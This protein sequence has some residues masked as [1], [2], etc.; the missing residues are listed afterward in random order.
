MSHGS[1]WNRNSFGGVLRPK[2]GSIPAIE[3][4][5][6]R[7]LL[8]ADI[9]VGIDPLDTS[10]TTPE[11]TGTVNDSAASIY[12][13]VNGTD[14]D[15][16]VN[17]GD[18]TWSL[19]DD[20]IAPALVDGT[21]DVEVLALNGL[22]WGVDTTTDEL[23]IDTI[24]PIVTINDLTTPDD[25]PELTGT[26]DQP[27][28]DIIVTV[29][30]KD[31][32]E[33]D[34]V[35]NNGDGTWT[36]PDDKIDPALTRGNTYEVTVTATDEAGNVGTDTTEKELTI[37]NQS[38][39]VDVLET[40]DRTPEL[41]G[42]LISPDPVTSVDV[43][44]DGLTYTATNNGNDTWTLANNTIASPLSDGTYDVTVTVTTD[45]GTLTD[46]STN[47]LTI[48]ATG[49]TVTVDSLTTNDTTPELTGTINDDEATIVVTVNETDYPAT[50]NQDGT[51]TLADGTL[52]A[53]D[54]DTYDVTVTGTDALGNTGT[55]TTEDELVIDTIAPVVTADS[56]TID[57]A[58]F[59]PNDPQPELTGTVD[60]DEATITV[61]ILGAEYAATNNEDGTWTL[62]AD[63]TILRLF[64]GTY[65]LVVTATDPA[66]NEGT[67][68]TDNGLTNAPYVSVTSLGTSDN[69]PELTG[70]VNDPDAVVTV[71]ILAE[72]AVGPGTDY[73]AT[74]NTDGT[75]TLADGVIGPLAAGP[76]DVSLSA[77]DGDATYDED[78]AELFINLSTAEP[79]VTVDPLTTTFT[80]PPLSGTLDA[81]TAA[82][83]FATIN[84][85]VAGRSATATNNGD[86][87]W[88]LPEG[89]F[90]S[91]LSQNTYNVLVTVTDSAGNTA[92]DNTSGELRIRAEQTVT[93]R[94][95]GLIS[96]NYTDPDG[97][98]VRIKLTF[99]RVAGYVVLSFASNSLITFVHNRTAFGKIE[100]DAGAVVSSISI[101]NETKRIN[102]STR[103]GTVTGATIGGIGGNAT[104]RALVAS[105]MDLIDDGINM[106]SGIIESISLRSIQADVTMSG[107]GSK[108]VSFKIKEDVSGSNIR[109]SDC[110]VRSFLAGKMLNSS[111]YVGVMGTP[112]ENTDDVYDLPEIADL[113]V[114]HKILRFTI[115][116]YRGSTGDYF[117]NSN[118]AADYI[119]SVSLRNAT[120]DNSG[121]AF[122]LTANTLR[123]LSLRQDRSRYSWRNGAWNP[124]LT[125]DDLAVRL[126]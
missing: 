122:G 86:G 58:T 109:V 38:I 56:V 116:G 99:P 123:R 55:D 25:T 59:G 119:G 95:G 22:S 26:I 49:P 101:L 75:W 92:S 6:P 7:L 84:V 3:C 104:C 10:D 108:G 18:G 27:G 68:T 17:N 80:N 41:G 36:L 102:F 65:D 8:A 63:I 62:V 15:N 44:V 105:T 64:A 57:L 85:Y 47:E 90:S 37:Q 76:Y 28:T 39:T 78:G 51:W 54:D 35:T 98:A 9:T 24:N 117:T 50:N 31:Y 96:L 30:G 12:V 115:K 121:E 11:L 52:A 72:G 113:L 110:N 40:N 61:S 126:V 111:L 34:G 120:L 19:A 1:G 23:T 46:E 67:S 53:L 33:D 66:G 69:T 70:M 81:N 106:P 97:T 114:D 45:G 124:L 88:T 79:V 112:D 5:E 16:A 32:D 118:I 77:D 82:D 107:V 43:T 20:T 89:S 13:S 73:V 2:K 71:T 125:A 83:L 100:A 87:T 91:T 42:D 21:Y 14:Y 4:L 93:M 60:D 48:D 29:D 74:N 94:S 103:G